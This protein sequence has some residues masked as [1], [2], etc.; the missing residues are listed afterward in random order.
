MKK[1]LYVAALAAVLS[2]CYKDKGSYDYHF[3]K[4]NYIEDITF[5]PAAF[6]G[7][8]GLTVELQQP[9]GEDKVERV[10]AV[11]SQS[12]ATDLK[13]VD[14]WW[15][16]TYR[17][18]NQTVKDT[19]TTVGY[20][21]VKLP[22]GKD[23]EYSVSLKV[24][25]RVSTLE[26][27][28][29]FIISTR[30]IFKN[31]LFVLHGTPGSMKLGNVEH[32]GGRDV[33]RTD[34]WAAVNTT[35][36]NPFANAVGLAS[37]AYYDFGSRKTSENLCVFNLDGSASLYQPFGLESKYYPGYV[38]PKSD[39]PFLYRSI[40]ETGNTTSGNDYKLLL[41]QDG[42]FYVARTY[43]SFHQPAGIDS[44]PA[45]YEIKAATITASSFVGWDERNNRF[46]Y[47]S[48]GDA[49]A[50]EEK[51]GRDA[52]LYQMIL[53]AN[54]DLSG[55]G[56][57]LDLTTKDAVYAYIQYREDYES[58]HPFFLF[59]DNATGRYYQ[60]ELTPVGGGKDEKSAST[61]GS[62]EGDKGESVDGRPAFT[63]TGKALNRFT[64]TGQSTIIYN[65]WFTAN[66]L[67]CAEDNKVYRYNASSGDKVLIY[68]APEG[69]TVTH[70]RFRSE[71]SADFSGDLG[72]YLMIGLN[73]A[74]RGAVAEVLLTTAGDVDEAFVVP[75]YDRDAEGNHFGPIKD[76][77]FAREYKYKKD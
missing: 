57:E 77:V 40:V 23:M 15:E 19:V 76:L 36:P 60:Y 52:S 3:D 48:N 11:L 22:A 17:E 13:D 31:S 64:P 37:T 5:Q 42:K 58:S 14:F 49:F 67:F 74:G 66:N 25:D 65:T 39:T 73:N 34:A 18:N 24:K 27:Y 50:W 75:F 35:A 12:L 20:L 44:K 9:I 33:V 53:D 38:L 45:D 63:I 61:R 54:V 71:D 70:L 55:L 8:K 72:R 62:D 6:N 16:L 68:T 30:A 26:R 41:S 47:L 59:R 29:R 2:S 56:G 32:V 28:A 46:L 7:I 51:G 21:D 69:Y 4:V 43:Y 1:I 10:Q